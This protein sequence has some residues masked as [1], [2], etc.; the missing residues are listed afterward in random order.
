MEPQA[1]SAEPGLIDRLLAE[2]HRFSFFQLVQL[3]ERDR[4]G[5][6]PLGHGGPAAAEALR[7]RPT[8][9]LAFPKG[10][11]A[12]VE[13]GADGRLVVDVAFLGLYG[14]TS[15][16]PNF[17]SEDLLQD[18]DDEQV[19]RDF[20]DVFHHR[21]LSLFYRAWAKYRHHVQYRTGATDPQSR[22]VLCLAGHGVVRPAPDALVPAPLLLRY[23][24]LL[25]RRPGSAAA[26]RAGLSDYF[27]GVAV[28]VVPC[29][30]RWVTVADD[31]CTRLGRR[32]ARL[33]VD[34]QV[35]ERVFDRAG[36][37]IVALGPLTLEQYV[38]FLPGRRERAVLAE[39]ARLIATDVLT[40]Q[41]EL[42]LPREEVPPL[43]LGGP[44]A[45]LGWTTWLGR[46]AGDAAVV[47]S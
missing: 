44:L 4:A 5:A 18:D 30:P 24:G 35:G 10:D 36:A 2:P 3:I 22:R 17:Y 33:G 28:D 8:L 47:F 42:T 40:P 34:I 38:A 1:R 46:P 19:V 29:A 39:L 7:L 14:S 26:V 45:Q 12:A 43:R 16:L 21:L 15:P 37:Y 31:A 6:A 9:S 27:T 23:A 32:N 11:V 20:L 41:L 13:R 25:A